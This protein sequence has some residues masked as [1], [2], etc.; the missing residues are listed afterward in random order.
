MEHGEQQP[1]DSQ[2]KSNGDG[3]SAIG[4]LLR[5]S[6]LRCGEDLREVAQILCIRQ[7]YLEAIEEGNYEELPGPAYASGFVRAY[8][9]HLGLDGEEVVRRFRQETSDIKANTELYFLSPIP[10]SGIPSG[11]IILVG[12]LVALLAYGGWYLSTSNEEFVA[13]LISPLP[14]RLMGGLL[15]GDEDDGDKAEAPDN[16][17]G[18]TEPSAGESNDDAEAGE[19]GET[20]AETE[21]TDAETT[22]AETTAPDAREGGESEGA[23]ESQS[24]EAES[25]SAQQAD[26]E[27][28]TETTPQAGEGE[29]EA[30]P[31]PAASEEPTATSGESA[32]QGPSTEP[33]ATQTASAQPAAESPTPEEERPASAAETESGSAPAGQGTEST[34]RIL[35]RARADSWIQIRDEKAD[36]LVVARLLRAG[37]SYNV[38]D[39]EGLKLLTGNAGALD[40]L[41]DG[42]IVPPIGPVGAVRRAVSLKPDL[43]L[44]GKAVGD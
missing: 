17:A 38:P 37:D 39:R 23:D 9:E 33:E 26:A 5:A 6:R 24:A 19:A 1:R 29:S 41:V 42:K 7:P 15:S 32:D 36:K 28:T 40:I 35:V 34:T 13:D 43:L 31:T 44:E 11:A 25:E 14:D 30:T 16:A 4:G 10:E 21:T 8:A 2:D 20:A 27:A 12:V 3:G 22:D 18:A